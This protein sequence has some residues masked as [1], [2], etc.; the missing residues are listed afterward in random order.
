[1]P[2]RLLAISAIPSGAIFLLSTALWLRGLLATDIWSSHL[3]DPAARSLY[4]RSVWATDG[5]VY[6]IRDTTLVP[7]GTA[8]QDKPPMDG[9]WVL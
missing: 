1:M 6:L 3:W 2:R 5:W 9:T 8:P 7:P 4:S